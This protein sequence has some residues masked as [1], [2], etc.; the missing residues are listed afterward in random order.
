MLGEILTWLATPSTLAARRLG[1][2]TAAIGL[3][4]RAQ[5]CH[6][7]WADHLA[8]CR[9]AVMTSV[10]YC[11]RHRTALVLGAG[12]A[13]EYPLELLAARFARVVLADIVHLPA[14]RRQ[15][16]RYPNVELLPCDLTGAVAA[17]TQFRRPGTTADLDRI[18]AAPPDIAVD[19]VDWVVSCNALSQLPLLPVAWLKRRN[20]QLADAD[21]ERWG[22]HIMA[23]HLAWLGTLGSERCLIADAVQTTYDRRGT[24][25][26]RADFAAAFGLDR[27]AYATWEWPV[28]PPGE[29]S[30]GLYASHRVVACRWP[31]TVSDAASE[32][33]HR[34]P[35]LTRT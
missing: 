8:H 24:V 19:S 26:E 17:L 16:R 22:R 21:L 3:A 35:V 14:L 7:A 30:D 23:R 2:V 20:P 5:R 25:L 6:H 27:H 13:L 28:A 10:S 11:N 12:L 4:A 1:Y 34:T 15:A 32:Q 9:T 29:L 31:A 18:G 33:L